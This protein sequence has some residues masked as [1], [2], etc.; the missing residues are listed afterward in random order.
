MS[1]SNVLKTDETIMIELSRYETA[2]QERDRYRSMCHRMA[3]M[4]QL[5]NENIDDGL[6]K[7]ARL[8]SLS[9]LEDYKD[10]LLAE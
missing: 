4:F 1:E 9:M 8:L 6:P 2:V 3:Y 5:I 10:F 7:Q